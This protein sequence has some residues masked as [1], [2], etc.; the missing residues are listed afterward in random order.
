MPHLALNEVIDH[1]GD[2]SPSHLHLSGAINCTIIP[3]C[4]YYLI[5]PTSA[6]LSVAFYYSTIDEISHPHSQPAR[7]RSL[8]IHFVSTC[9]A[10]SPLRSLRRRR[11][12]FLC[13]PETR[14]NLPRPRFFLSGFSPFFGT[15]YCRVEEWEDREEG[16]KTLLQLRGSPTAT[17]KK[18]AKR[19]SEQERELLKNSDDHSENTG[20]GS[21]PGGRGLF[22][23]FCCNIFFLSSESA[24]RPARKLTLIVRPMTHFGIPFFGAKRVMNSTH[25]RSSTHKPVPGRTRKP[26]EKKQFRGILRFAP[27]FFAITQPFFAPKITNH[28]SSLSYLCRSIFGFGW[29][30]TMT[31]LGETRLI[32][33]ILLDW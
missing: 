9:S 33:K 30:D 28:R 22:G 32:L 8:S 3:H 6:L 12:G 23:I 29:T 5:I 10:R 21:S 2:S 19:A 4:C 20:F 17:Q 27:H 11:F 1:A 31:N 24:A 18:T 14:D 16:K 13:I 25:D 15:C 26:K 7:A